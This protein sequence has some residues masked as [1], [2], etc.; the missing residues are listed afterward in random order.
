MI[1]LVAKRWLK[2]GAW[3]EYIALAQ[4]LVDQT[5]Q[6]PGCVDYALYGVKE[7]A[8]AV[9]METWADQGSLDAHL[10]RLRAENWGARL[11]VYAD[12]ERPPVIEKYLEL[13]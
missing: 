13:Y 8:L 7:D 11:N 1:K 2:E 6:E 9:M 5:R 4:K 3:D 10:A 12:P